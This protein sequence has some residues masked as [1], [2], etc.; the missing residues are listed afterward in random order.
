M[1]SKKSL[2]NGVVYF[3]KKNSLAI[4]LKIYKSYQN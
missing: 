3:K 2:T 4:K 1:L